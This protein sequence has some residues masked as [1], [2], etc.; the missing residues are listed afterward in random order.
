MDKNKYCVIPEYDTV[1]FLIFVLLLLNKRCCMIVRTNID[2]YGL[3]LA[4]KTTRIDAMK[5]KKTVFDP[6]FLAQKPSALVNIL[7]RLI[8]HLIIHSCYVLD[9]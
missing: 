2:V 8:C 4:S 7:K 9:V 1:G 5:L 3:L 6:V